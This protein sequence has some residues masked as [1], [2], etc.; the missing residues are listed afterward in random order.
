MNAFDPTSTASE[1]NIDKEWI[2]QNINED[3]IY[4]DSLYKQ[5]QNKVSEINKKQ[6]I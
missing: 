6:T 3:K 2:D 1:L 5:W 4:I